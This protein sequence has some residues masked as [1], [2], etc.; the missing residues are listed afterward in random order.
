HAELITYLDLAVIPEKGET[1]ADD[2]V[3]SSSSFWIVFVKSTCG[4][5]F[6][7]L[8]AAKT[9]TQTDVCIIDRSQNGILLLV[10]EDNR[11][12]LSEPSTRR[13]SL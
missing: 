12:E 4:R 1:P 6:R 8:F 7:F 2:F 13:L 3:A 5:T 10:Q 11:L 9:G